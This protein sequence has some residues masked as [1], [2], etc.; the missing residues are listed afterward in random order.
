MTVTTPTVRRATKRSLFW[1]LGAVF[2]VLIAVLTM[3]ITGAS[4]PGGSPLSATNAGPAGSMAIAEVLR[5]QGVTVTVTDSLAA[6]RDAVTGPAD[7]TV[8][9]FDDGGYL[10]AQVLTEAV[11]LAQHV[12]L[13][14]PSFDALQA[15]APGIAQA[16][17][18]GATALKSDCDLAA[19]TRAGTVSGGGSGYRV[20]A[21]AARTTGCLG[22]G[23]RIFSLVQVADGS[24]RLTILGTSRAFSNEQVAQRG[25]AALALNLLG[26]THTL[27][28]YLPSIADLAD[29]G[30]PGIAELTPPWVTPVMALL[31]CIVIAAAFWRG[32][33][34]GPLIVENLPVVV[35]AS[36]T[37]EGRARLY[38][39]A[40][41]RLRALDS[42]RVGAIARLATARGLPRLSS[43]DEVI[44]A[45]SSVTGIDQSRIRTLLIDE[46]PGTDRDLVRLSDSLLEL[47][48]VVAAG[49][50][51]SAIP[52]H[53]E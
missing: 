45:V 10:D 6:T 48:R 39:K 26:E 24:H 27:V 22:S 40:S 41:A 44:S 28:W 20:I 49:A 37:M 32:R 43:V 1:I 42:L 34:L 30:T 38:Q 29:T 25:N 4:G 46:T 31:F 47:E 13:M 7:T 53:G 23:D 51:P 17:T 15:L 35:R 9:I 14:T 52:N 18:V 21:D 36:E 33:R 5:H 2:V 11:G 16:G 50:R 3:V 12:V 8:F 19:V